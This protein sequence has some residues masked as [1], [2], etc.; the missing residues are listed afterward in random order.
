MGELKRLKNF[1]KREMPNKPFHNFS[2]IQ[3]VANVA[4]SMGSRSELLRA[5][6]YLHDVGH[7]QGANG[8]EKRSAKI[9]RETLPQY[10]YSEQEANDIADAIL[11]TELFKEPR[12]T[13]G[14]VL[15]DADTHNFGLKFQK[16]K[17]ISL[18]VKKEEEP[19][20]TK[21]EWWK[22]VVKLLR[23]HCYQGPGK[24]RYCQQKR[25]NISNLEDLLDKE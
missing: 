14:T 12:T 17:S 22:N 9:A 5:A 18:Q 11:D 24:E 1:S 16:F 4:S 20:S 7:R 3:R 10:G 15:S 21:D 8:H 23:S 25:Q 2:H 6:A 19:S 13:M